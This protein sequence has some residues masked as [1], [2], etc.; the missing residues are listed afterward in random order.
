MIAYMTEHIDEGSGD[1]R[2]LFGKA[3]QAACGELGLTL[4][5]DETEPLWQHYSLMVSANRTTNLT[6]ITAPAEAA[7]K[8]YADSLALLPWA[9]ELVSRDATLLDVGTG[10]GFP[11]VPLAVCRL[12]W[13]IVAVDSTRKK[14][15]FVARAAA[16][17]GLD[18]VS[19]QQV[20]ARELAGRAE[21]FELVTCRA[22][23]D[24]VGCARETRRLVAP[25]GWLVCYS[26]PRAVE[27][28][29]ESQ[30]GQIQRMGFGPLQRHEYRLVTKSE[31]LDRVL[32]IWQRS[33]G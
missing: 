24:L 33:N 1:A 9:D 29:T 22:V 10:A 2:V 11:A 21:P 18:H 3:L 15:S 6:R 8:H 25:G 32:A 31:S 26:T 13:R 5:A 4:D 30:A 12:D 20:R 19:V 16:S 28:L 14:A 27:S 7:V 17:L 23:A